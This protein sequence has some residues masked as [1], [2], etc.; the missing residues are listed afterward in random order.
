MYGGA[1]R[2][3][4]RA[5]DCPP[6]G[7]SSRRHT[8]D[9]KTEFSLDI[10]HSLRYHMAM[11]NLPKMVGLNAANA[12]T[13]PRKRG[14]CGFVLDVVYREYPSLIR[15]TVV[16]FYLR[17]VS[18]VSLPWTARHPR[19]CALDRQAQQSGGQDLMEQPGRGKTSTIC[20][21]SSSAPNTT[22]SL[23]QSFRLEAPWEN[24]F[25]RISYQ[26]EVDT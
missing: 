25:M 17:T 9:Y 4:G 1:D 6:E 21:R 13:L 19:G 24:R 11:Q 7:S 10:P 12:T 18:A 14:R 16:S 22:D 23:F 26:K 15:P 20:H 8:P 2:M 3:E 5:G